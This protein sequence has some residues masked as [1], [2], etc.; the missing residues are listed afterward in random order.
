MS[1]AEMLQ[2]WYSDEYHSEP[3]R[4]LT[5][6]EQQFVKEAI[7]GYF[8]LVY[9]ADG[10]PFAMGGARTGNLFSADVEEIEDRG[11]GRGSSIYR[12]RQPE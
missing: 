6:D 12:L 2:P 4:E 7:A 3:I 8:G 11:N 5:A 10:H 9:A 1:P